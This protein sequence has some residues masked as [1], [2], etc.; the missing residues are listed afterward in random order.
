M[1]RRKSSRTHED[2]KDA[3][4]S[5]TDATAQRIDQ[6]RKREQESEAL[7]RRLDRLAGADS[8]H[9]GRM[10]LKALTEKYGEDNT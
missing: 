7:L 8:N 3:E 6:Q 10:V 1:F 2:L 4:Q 9:L 5:L